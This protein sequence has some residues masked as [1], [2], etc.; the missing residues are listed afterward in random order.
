MMFKTIRIVV[1]L[2]VTVLF[3][4]TG[5]TEEAPEAHK[6]INLSPETLVLL[7]AE[8]RELAVAS[9]A[10]VISYVSGDWKSIQRISE[11]IRNS[12]VMEQNLTDAQKQELADKLP[13]GFKRLDVDFHSRADRLE[14]AAAQK[15]SEL[16]A[17]HYYRL[18]ESCATCHAEYAASRFPGFSSSETEIHQ[19]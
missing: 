9:Q 13:E 5:Y 10:M 4:S 2:T 15:N 8:M 3:C 7:Q 18:L 19:H 12:Y 14:S 11:Q 16:V 17:F 6:T 1:A